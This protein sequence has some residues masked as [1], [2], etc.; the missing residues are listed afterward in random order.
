MFSGTIYPVLSRAQITLRG[1]DVTL[2]TTPVLHQIDLTVTATSRIAVVGENGRGKTTLL[3]VLTGQLTPDAGSIT[4][5]GT[6]GVAE[7]DM[8]VDDNRTVGDAIAETIAP[9]VAALTEFEAASRALAE[10]QQGA[11]DRFSTLR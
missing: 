8:P 1:V 10:E 5:H 11:E 3:H 7:Q 2:G 4:R 9:A 6:I